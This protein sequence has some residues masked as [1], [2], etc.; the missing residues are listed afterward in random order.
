MVSQ[1]YIQRSKPLSMKF[2]SKADLRLGKQ[3]I[4]NQA[5]ELTNVTEFDLNFEINENQ[6]RV[7]LKNIKKECQWIFCSG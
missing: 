7:N 6:V 1:A 5:G 3:S 2:F 4:A